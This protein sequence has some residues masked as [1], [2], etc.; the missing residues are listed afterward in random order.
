MEQ[1]AL[2]R[3]RL[4][5]DDVVPLGLSI[6]GR[7]LRKLLHQVRVHNPLSSQQTREVVLQEEKEQLGYKACLLNCYC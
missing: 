6:N 7:Q 4:V 3:R 2:P 1:L 5:V